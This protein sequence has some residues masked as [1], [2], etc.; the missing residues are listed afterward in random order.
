MKN[1]NIKNRGFSLTGTLVTWALGL[2]AL[3]GGGSYV[4]NETLNSEVKLNQNNNM[5]QVKGNKDHDFTSNQNILENIAIGEISDTERDGLIYM[6]EEEKLAR[7]VYRTLYDQWGLQVFENISYSESRHM[8]SVKELLDRYQI[9]DPVIDDAT[10]EFTLP[11]MQK[12][13][14]DLV[15]QGSVSLVEALK[16]GAT[17]EDLDIYDLNNWIEKTD[18]E[19]IKIVYE[20]L[21]RGSRNHMRSFIEQLEKQGSNY[22]AQYISQEEIDAI[23]EGAREQG[24]GSDQQSE[25][26]QRG[27]NKD[28]SILRE[29]GQ[30]QGNG[31]GLRDGGG[32]GQGGGMMRNNR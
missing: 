13:Y 7:D 4:A 27:F 8:S 2:A 5:E 18:N 11:E 26:N 10:G 9:T 31:Q 17:I 23:L 30:R 20:N 15:A 16:V 19:D 6:R 1:Y 28:D 12:L 25:K 3:F 21:A 32:Q 14:D 24:Q 22:N 29:Q